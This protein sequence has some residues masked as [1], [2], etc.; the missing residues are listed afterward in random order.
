MLK[1]KGRA[2][3][4]RGLALTVLVLLGVA[5][6][7]VGRRLI[8][9][10]ISPSVPS[11]LYLRAR[12][13][14]AVGRLV[15]FRIPP[16][17]RAY[18]LSRTGNDGRDWY[19]LKPI[20]AGPGDRVDTTTGYLTINGRRIAPIMTCDSAGRPLPVWRDSRQLGPGEFFVFSGRIPNSFDSR[21]FGPVR[22][23]QIESVRRPLVTW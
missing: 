15:D 19:I 3:V 8:V 2:V 7:T 10:N 16:S 14:P 1:P 4:T 18:V 12:E 9:I 22:R 20:V 23:E 17:A 21:Y 5:G 6:Q 13:E 11:G